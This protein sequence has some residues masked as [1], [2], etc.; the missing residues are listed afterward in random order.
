MGVDV[1]QP[2]QN[3]AERDLAEQSERRGAG[4]N[5]GALAFMPES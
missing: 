5:L 2:R 3:C 4:G 1:D